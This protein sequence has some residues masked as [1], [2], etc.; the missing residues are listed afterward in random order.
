MYANK[1]L[2][3]VDESV[4]REALN[5]FYE[6]RAGVRIDKLYIGKSLR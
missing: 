3:S 5:N 1:D 2:I 4:Q 6:R